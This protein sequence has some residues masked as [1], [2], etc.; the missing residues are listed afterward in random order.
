MACPT[1][2]TG[3][4]FDQLHRQSGGETL[5]A[6]RTAA[7]QH[8]ATTDGLGT[9][10]ETVTALAYELGRLI[11]PFHRAKPLARPSRSLEFWGGFNPWALRLAECEAS[12]PRPPRTKPHPAPL[13]TRIVAPGRLTSRSRAYTGVRRPSQRSAATKRINRRMPTGR[14]SPIRSSPAAALSV[15]SGMPIRSTPIRRRRPVDAN[16]P[17]AWPR[18]P[19]FRPGTRWLATPAKQ[20]IDKKR[21][22]AGTSHRYCILSASNRLTSCGQPPNRR[23][24]AQVAELVDALAS[25]ASVARREGSS[26]FLG[27]TT[28]F[29]VVR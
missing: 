22:R 5:A 6:A 3:Q 24:V 2:G 1:C 4:S 12:L 29:L 8:E 21:H 27:T 16:S 23:A 10:A 25:G 15:M 7:R 20:K 9:S 19:K 11:G 26:P 13:D 28:P 18:S 14:V 17:P